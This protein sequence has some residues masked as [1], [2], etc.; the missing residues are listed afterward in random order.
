M[1]LEDLKSA[2]Q[3]VDLSS[4]HNIVSA[5]SPQNMTNNRR[6]LATSPRSLDELDGSR[7]NV[8]ARSNVSETTAVLSQIDASST[9]C[10]VCTSSSFT[11]SE[12]LST[13]TPR[14]INLTNNSMLLARQQLHRSAVSKP[15][16]QGFTVPDL[17]SPFFTAFPDKPDVNMVEQLADV[18]NHSFEP[19]VGGPTSDDADVEAFAA[20]SKT[21][22]K[23]VADKPKDLP[24]TNELSKTLKRNMETEKSRDQQG[25]K[26]HV[27]YATSVGKK[28][29]SAMHEHP[30]PQVPPGRSQTKIV[31]GVTKVQTVKNPASTVS[32]TT[33]KIDV[34]AVLNA[35][36][37][38]EKTISAMREHP[39]PQVPPDRSQKK[40]ETSV[41][42]VQ[43]VKNPASTTKEIDVTA[44]AAKKNRVEIKLPLDTFTLHETVRELLKNQDAPSVFTL[45]ET[46]KLLRDC[47]RAT[48]LGSKRTNVERNVKDAAGVERSLGDNNPNA[49]VETKTKP[50]LAASVLL[51][52][53]SK[54][55]DTTSLNLTE[56][57]AQKEIDVKSGFPPSSASANTEATKTKPS[58]ISDGVPSHGE[59][60]RKILRVTIEPPDASDSQRHDADTKAKEKIRLQIV[61]DIPSPM[62]PA[63]NQESSL[64]PSVDVYDKPISD[65]VASADDE[66]PSSAFLPEEIPVA[67]DSNAMIS[68]RRLFPE[69]GNL[70]KVTLVPPRRSPRRRDVFEDS[71]VLHDGVEDGTSSKGS[72]NAESIASTPDNST[73]GQSAVDEVEVAEE[74]DGKALKPH[75]NDTTATGQS[76]SDESSAVVAVEDNRHD[77]TSTL[78]VA[79]IEDPILY[80][81]LEDS[82]SGKIAVFFEET[83][84]GKFPLPKRKPRPDDAVSLDRSSATSSTDLPLDIEVSR[85]EI[86]DM[87]ENLTKALSKAAPRVLPPPIPVE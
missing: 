76:S 59:D 44:Q 14:K 2:V 39:E 50:S 1:T 85:Q 79:D 7:S 17:Q 65:E 25:A 78:S 82:P 18:W 26:V 31:T 62:S 63:D 49:S 27:S 5:V 15:P 69:I 74:A 61:E 72:D 58:T 46:V 86:G 66:R 42:K 48:G 81:V 6:M 53:K 41:T 57:P 23:L 11:D 20:T 56:A 13:S 21:R 30:E 84:V 12:Q 54:P 34:T 24:E 60:T 37:V 4:S 75:S 45:H 29:I 8:S 16:Q 43:A 73:S 55:A 70:V 68:L 80:R 87:Q 22:E 51:Q 52:G 47:S 83:K 3:N 36:S 19:T 10:S 71:L 9:V 32:Q 77:M 38:A 35:T 67:V 64:P 33:K 40:I 28:T